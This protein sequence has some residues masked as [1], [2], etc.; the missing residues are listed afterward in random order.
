[1]PAKK[2]TG[3]LGLPPLTLKSLTRALPYAKA[4]V[5]EAGDILFDQGSKASSL[6]IIRSG[7]VQVSRV[8]RQEQAIK[9][10]VLAKGDFLG[11]MALLTGRKRSA[12]A[13][14]LS[15]VQVVELT[16]HDLRQ[17]LEVDTEM[18]A[19]LGMTFALLLANRLGNALELFT[20]EAV[21]RQLVENRSSPID[22]SKVLR[23]MHTHCLV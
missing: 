5:F 20:S 9:L 3:V 16:R 6:F 21:F 2:Q 7:R 1:M 17:L 12:R 23:D 10:G 4:K 19:H 13:T 11:E 22:I 18:A 15:R 14:A 8:F